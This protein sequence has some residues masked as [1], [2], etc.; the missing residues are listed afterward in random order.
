MA[1]FI[2]WIHRVD[3]TARQQQL[4]GFP[5]Q[6]S[7]RQK[8]HFEILNCVEIV[9]EFSSWAKANA[10]PSPTTLTKTSHS[11]ILACKDRRTIRLRALVGETQVSVH[12]Q[13]KT[14]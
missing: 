1:E 10:S 9:Q 12:L 14:W 13:L 4:T 3:S 7:R 11:G 5:S 6:H 8:A 2:P